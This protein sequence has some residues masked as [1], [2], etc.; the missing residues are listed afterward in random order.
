MSKTYYDQF[1]TNQNGFNGNSN[2]KSNGK[3]PPA[4]PTAVKGSP[5]S[6]TFVLPTKR[7][8][9]NS[10]GPKNNPVENGSRR[11]PVKEPT[12][13]NATPPPPKRRLEPVQ[14]F[15]TNRPAPKY[16]SSP[17]IDPQDLG[18]RP[19][20]FATKH[21]TAYKPST[22]PVHYQKSTSLTRNAPER[23]QQRMRIA[24]SE[25]VIQRRRQQAPEHVYDDYHT[26]SAI[27]TVILLTKPLFTYAFITISLY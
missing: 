24:D 11:Q 4:R 8:D 6:D 23:T 16:V 22:P 7:N 12:L 15:E 19:V 27:L 5:R 17:P 2:M 10:K 26:V 21:N 25:Y 18:R 13:R 9:I 3:P 20:R 14:R 1:R